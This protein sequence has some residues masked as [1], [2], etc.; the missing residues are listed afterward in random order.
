[1]SG[2]VVSLAQNDA[3]LKSGPDRPTKKKKKNTKKAPPF[4]KKSG[5]ADAY[6]KC[7]P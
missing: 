1:M 2:T 4:T 7:K 5:I 6:M 3:L